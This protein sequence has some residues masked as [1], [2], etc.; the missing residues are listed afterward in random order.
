MAS[1]VMFAAGAAAA[2]LVV[3]HGFGSAKESADVMLDVYEAMLRSKVQA[4]KADADDGG[5]KPKGIPTAS[6]V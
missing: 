2:M 6:R 4:S 3:L 5:E 1:W